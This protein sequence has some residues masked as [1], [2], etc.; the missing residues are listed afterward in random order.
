MNK[1]CVITHGEDADGI[2]SN[3][4]LQKYVLDKNPQ[5]NINMVLATHDTLKYNIKEI[6]DKDYDEI[7]FADLPIESDVI[8]DSELINLARNKKIFYFDHHY[9]SPVRED[10][11]NKLCCMV[12]KDEKNCATQIIRSVLFNND[13]F[14]TLGE[15]AQATDFNLVNQY[16]GLGDKLRRII[17]YNDSKRMNKVIEYIRKDIFFTRDTVHEEFREIEEDVR[18]K[19]DR[20]LQNMLQSCKCVKIGKYQCVI[21]VAEDIIYMKFAMINLAL[22]Y[23]KADLVGVLGFKRKNVGLSQALGKLG[24]EIPVMEICASQKGGGRNN[25]GGYLLKEE[26]TYE[27]Y[28]YYMD[29]VIKLLNTFLDK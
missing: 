5:A 18:Q 17:D 10:L 21:G 13:E 6:M 2:I 9:I 27:N 24:S 1:V 14:A 28:E 15:I 12:Y 7:Y 29:E 19:E 11:L 25:A 4:L 23:P 22:N 26:V 8:S 3:A 16:Y 20:A